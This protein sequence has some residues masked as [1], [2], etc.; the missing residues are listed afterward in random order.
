MGILQYFFM[1]TLINMYPLFEVELLNMQVEN[2]GHLK[3][4]SPD[5]N[6]NITF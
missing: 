4:T 3:I 6:H 2:V 5:A 1:H